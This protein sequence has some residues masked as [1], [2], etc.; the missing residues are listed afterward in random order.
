MTIRIFTLRFNRLLMQDRQL[1]R[2]KNKTMVF[3][4]R[5]SKF[6]EMN[7][8]FSYSNTHHEESRQ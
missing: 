2:L 8:A 7:A 4:I 1:A 3:S 5:Q 6:N